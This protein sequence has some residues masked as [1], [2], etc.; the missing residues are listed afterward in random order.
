VQASL[1]PRL[2]PASHTPGY[3]DRSPA[4]FVF[5]AA[6]HASR[7]NFAFAASFHWNTG[8]PCQSALL[9]WL[10]LDTSSQMPL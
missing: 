3:R 7:V 6:P 5:C 9:Y 8:F 10:Q 2:L 1:V 4:S